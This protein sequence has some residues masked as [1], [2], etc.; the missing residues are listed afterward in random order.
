MSSV[1]VL[2]FFANRDEARSAAVELNRRRLAR[3]AL[4]IKDSDGAL[5]PWAP[6]S[7]RRLVGAS[8]SIVIWGGLL[9]LAAIVFGWRAPFLPLFLSVPAISLA[10]SMAALVVARLW[11]RRTRFGGERPPLRP[12]ARRLVADE[13]LLI[14]QCPVESAP[15][16]AGIL[17]ESGEVPPVLF[18][19]HPER[20]APPGP[21]PSDGA[22]L[23]LPELEAHARRLATDHH[24]DP[25]PPRSTE[26]LR[27]LDAARQWIHQVSLDLAA[28]TRL[29]QGPSPVAEWILD[30]EYIIE[31]NARDVRLNLPRRYYQEL[32]ALK[33]GQGTLPRIYGLATELTAH[34]DARLERDNIVAFLEAY[35]TLVPLTIGELWAYPQ[36]L[37]IALI[38]DIQGQADRALIQLREREVADYWA[39]RLLTVSRRDPTALFGILAELTAAHPSPT[40]YFAAQLVDHLYDEDAALGPGQ[41]WRERVFRKPLAEVTLKEQT[42]QSQAQTAVSNAF[43]SLR[44]LAMLDWRQVFEDLS[45]VERIL[46]RDPAGVYAYM[47]FD[48]RDL[49]RRAVEGLAP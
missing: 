36:M 18:F 8:L 17:R 1:V 47:D 25:R 35:Q 14:L 32:P 44:Q 29:D 42:R 5:E 27:R 48:T 19:F 7:R 10:G 40:P 2:G 21:V 12:P 45:H 38:E 31:A 37:R 15:A 23:S 28:A 49:Y 20:P 30:N 41:G 4:L 26:L 6:F 22:A 24:L 46:R 11:F 16:A 33:N 43:P 34:A 13:S 9:G 3:A 39:N